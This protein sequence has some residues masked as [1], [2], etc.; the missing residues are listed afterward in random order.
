[1]KEPISVDQRIAIEQTF[2]CDLPLLLANFKGPLPI[3]T[4]AQ[5]AEVLT[6]ELLGCWC[7]VAGALRQ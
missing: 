1:M 3:V 7:G 4:R 2:V 5:L 6:R